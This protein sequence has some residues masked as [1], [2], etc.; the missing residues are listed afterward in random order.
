M[1]L[2]LIKLNS[3]L[4]HKSNFCSFYMILVED[5]KKLEKEVSERGPGEGFFIKCDVSKEEDIKVCWIRLK[6]IRHCMILI[7]MG[8]FKLVAY[9]L[10]N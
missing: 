3:E 7:E 9:Q 10:I 1:I 6:P 5:G 8:L 4:S 2:M